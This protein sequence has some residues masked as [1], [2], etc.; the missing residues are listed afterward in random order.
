[1]T[2]SAA[3]S[4]A[5][6][7][8]SDL[9]GRLRLF[10]D[11]LRHSPALRRHCDTVLTG[12]HWLRGFRLNS[13]AGSL[14]VRFPEARRPEV[15]ALLEEALAPPA[16]ADDT[17]SAVSRRRQPLLL[18]HG[19]LCVAALALDLWLGLPALLINGAAALLTLPLLVHAWQEM[20]RRPPHL[21]EVLDVGLSA[22]LLR[23][24]HGREALVDQLLEDSSAGLQRLEEEKGRE[25]PQLDVLRRLGTLVRVQPV[26][27]A[28]PRPL[29]AVRVG[30][31][32]R[33]E[34][35]SRVWLALELVAGQVGVIR[36]AGA[37]VWSPLARGPGERL[38]AGWLVVAGEGVARVRSTIA[39][40]VRFHLPPT[41]TPAMTEEPLL[42]QLLR[43]QDRLVDPLLL[44]LGGIWAL[45]GA[46]ERA[47]AAFQFNPLSDWRT[48]QVALR[49]ATGAD[50]RRHG[51]HMAHPRVLVD[52]AR[53]DHLLVSPDC[54]D[55]LDREVPREH[56]AKASGLRPGDLLQLVAHLRRH[57]LQPTRD[58]GWRPPPRE[59]W[60]SPAG[61]D[62]PD[63]WRPVRVTCAEGGQGWLVELKN[64][65]RLTVR[66]I[67]RPA[68][69]RQAEALDVREGKVRLGTVTLERQV[70]PAWQEVCDHL[71][72]MGITVVPLTAPETP[73][74]DVGWRL[75]AVT[76][77]QRQ[78]GVVAWL[79][80]DLADIP[81]MTAAEVA[82]GLPSPRSHLL[83]ANLL[84]LTVGPD[85]RWVPRLV[86]LSR[87]LE[88]A[89]RANLWVIAFAHVFSSLA[90]AGLALTPLQMVLLADL[91]LLLAEL[92][93]RLA[94]ARRHPTLPASA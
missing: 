28:E 84:D 37:G 36:P 31:H 72:Q 44:A 62:E 7:I 43:L 69:H 17:G 12:C 50:M 80:D 59:D 23:Q 55:R 73:S 25:A 94:S 71:K 15:F 30:D 10:L 32:L 3:P 40:E 33:L 68:D 89:S 77:L 92:N 93:N 9:P 35:G 14:S 47:M 66:Q 82:I 58:P 11:D 87:E 90:T 45:G 52:L 91:P 4:M 24:G 8:R 6:E 81:A 2:L 5:W 63:P 83:P 88:R 75:E 16:P 27:D 42:Q 22:L 34:P 70:D 67:A 48:S 18:R 61:A 60:P 78:G 53:V 85:P 79:G 21:T 56:R 20:R 49:L 57:L 38:E 86:G 41:H 65:R 29:S 13:L 1:M 46:M 64:G 19:S 26:D 51:I 76:T 39:E 54:L 74:D